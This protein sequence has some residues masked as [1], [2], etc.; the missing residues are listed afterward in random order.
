[1]KR[2]IKTKSIWGRA[3]ALGLIFLISGLICFEGQAE[4]P[5]HR[6][7]KGHS[8]GNGGNVSDDPVRKAILEKARGVIWEFSYIFDILPDRIQKKR[9]R[10]MEIFEMK[11]EELFVHTADYLYESDLE[12][13]CDGRPLLQ[14]ER[15]P[16]TLNAINCPARNQPPLGPLSAETLETN[17]KR[18]LRQDL[19]KDI[20]VVSGRAWVNL[21]AF[22]TYDISELP[23]GFPASNDPFYYPD[24][25]QFHRKVALCRVTKLLVHEINGLAGLEKTN[26]FHVTMEDVLPLMSACSKGGVVEWSRALVDILSFFSEYIDGLQ[27]R[28]M[29]PYLKSNNYPGIF[30]ESYRG[31]ELIE[32]SNLLYRIACTPDF[33]NSKFEAMAKRY[34]DVGRYQ[35]IGQELI[36]KYIYCAPDND[37]ISFQVSYQE[38]KEVNYLNSPIFRDYFGVREWD[39]SDG[40]RN[41]ENLYFRDWSYHLNQ[42]HPNSPDRAIRPITSITVAVPSQ[43]IQRDTAVFRV[44]DHVLPPNDINDET[45]NWDYL[46]I[47]PR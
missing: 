23:L 13:L 24:W 5:A 22:E 8:H 1:M 3:W 10:Y 7:R 12:A 28:P 38:G 36:Q 25:D 37:P 6:G 26:E 40:D 9:S 32:G 43:D 2:T 14:P 27:A 34:P 31:M 39:D 46:V 18:P 16:K 30:S 35:V 45:I 44:G 4:P 21:W 20:I 42:V 29:V 41:Q 17:E 15:N 19:S 47:Y 33:L 11:A